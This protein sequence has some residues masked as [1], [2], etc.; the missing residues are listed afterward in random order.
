[1]PRPAPRRRSC[2]RA[3][4]ALIALSACNGPEGA[5]ERLLRRYPLRLHARWTERTRLPDGT[6]E[7]EPM[8]ERWRAVPGLFPTWIVATTTRPGTGQA[9]TRFARY[10]LRGAGLLC[11]GASAFEHPEPLTPPKLVLPWDA[12]PG[13]W[14]AVHQVA[15]RTQARSCTL[16][17]FAGCADGRTLRCVVEDPSGT[18]TVESRYCGGVG[19]V[20]F[21]AET[22]RGGRTW[23]VRSVDLRDG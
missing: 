23:T 2:R 22:T 9:R 11:T 6:V 15:G 21:E 19:I 7:D 14:T 8:E 12:A 10:E 13:S 17:S 3:T 4:L 20:S 18:T 5:G 1:M 16:S